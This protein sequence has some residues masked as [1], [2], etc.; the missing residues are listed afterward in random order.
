MPGSD[1]IGSCIEGDLSP[2]RAITFFTLAELFAE[3]AAASSL[4][5]RKASQS[6]G[7]QAS[8]PLVLAH[9]LLGPRKGPVEERVP[10]LAPSFGRTHELDPSGPLKHTG[11]R[12]G[13][14]TSDFTPFSLSL[15]IG[16]VSASAVKPFLDCC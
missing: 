13:L 9:D 10:R 1:A 2:V 16:E 11:S 12:N 15:S 4:C 14:R 5:T 3:A 8:L 7:K 6:P